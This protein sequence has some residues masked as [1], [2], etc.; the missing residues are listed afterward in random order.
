MKTDTNS[1]KINELLL[2]G[3]EDI[4]EKENLLKKLKSGKKLRIKHGVD[5]TG[6]NI[7]IGRAIQFKKL[8]EFQ[9][10]GHQVVLIIGD[11]TAQIGDASDKQ[12]IRRPLSEEEI[13]KNM[14]DYEKQIGK[15]IVDQKAQNLVEKI[16]ILKKLVQ[17]DSVLFQDL[18]LDAIPFSI[19]TLIKTPLENHIMVIPIIYQNLL[20]I[21]VPK[22][23]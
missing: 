9:E 3:V 20:N 18:P 1:Q 10:L 13:R 5:P 12:A 22:Q 2:R 15:I 7:H 16:I 21:L 11:F 17:V 6:P 8:K 23:N 19:K 14:K 4:I